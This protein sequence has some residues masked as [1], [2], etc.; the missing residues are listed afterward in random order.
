MAKITVQALEFKE[1][2]DGL[3]DCVEEVTFD[4]ETNGITLRA[5]VS[6][7]ASIAKP[8]PADAPAN[9]T[10]KWPIALSFNIK[11]LSQLLAKALANV[12][13]EDKLT[14]KFTHSRAKI[15]MYRTAPIQS[16]TLRIQP[17]KVS[18]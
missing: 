12:G 5:M 13:T 2:I 3:K 16:T 14:I 8:L 18:R 1:I 15:E 7:V 11:S 9:Y 17:L 4:C 10:C 6:Q